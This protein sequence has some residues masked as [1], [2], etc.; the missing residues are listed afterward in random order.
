MI[1]MSGLAEDKR[2]GLNRINIP[3]IFDTIDV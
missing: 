2:K 3:S 1:T